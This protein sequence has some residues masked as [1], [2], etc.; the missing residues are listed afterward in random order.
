MKHD[1]ASSDRSEVRSSLI[2]Y[3]GRRWSI[4]RLMK[5]RHFLDRLLGDMNVD[6]K[7]HEL[8]GEDLKDAKPNTVIYTLDKK[9]AFRK[10]TTMSMSNWLYGVDPSDGKTFSNFWIELT[11]EQRDALKDLFLGAIFDLNTIIDLACF[12]ADFDKTMITRWSI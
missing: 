11:D 3:L 12:S 9:R 2:P 7:A 5:V 8:S 10:V 4:D 1:L 6:L